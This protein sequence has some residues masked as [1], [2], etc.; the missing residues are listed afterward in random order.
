MWRLILLP[1]IKI[2]RTGAENVRNSADFRALPGTKKEFWRKNE[3]FSEQKFKILREKLAG[4]GKI[5]RNAVK[6]RS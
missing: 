4:T 1:Q 6:K 2:W 5:R 3:C